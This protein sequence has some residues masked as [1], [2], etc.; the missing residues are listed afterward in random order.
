MLPPFKEVGYNES[1]Y[2]RYK[3]ASRKADGFSL[4]QVQTRFKSSKRAIE[5]KIAVRNKEDTIAVGEWVE[6]ILDPEQ[7][8][9]HAHSW[10]RGTIQA[11]RLPTAMWRKGKHISHPHGIGQAYFQEWGSYG[12]RKKMPRRTACGAN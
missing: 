3:S 8:Y 1:E 11:P 10:T 2:E 7:G 6:Q 9:K 5:Y 4:P 12:P